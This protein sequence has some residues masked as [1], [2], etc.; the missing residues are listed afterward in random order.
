VSLDEGPADLS[1]LRE[2]V[3]LDGVV[4][5]VRPRVRSEPEPVNVFETVGGIY[6]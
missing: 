4:L 6:L 3:H 2:N 1:D 5:R